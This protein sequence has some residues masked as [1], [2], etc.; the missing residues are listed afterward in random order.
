MTVIKVFDAIAQ[1]DELAGVAWD[2]YLE[3][4][5]EVN[6]LAANRHLMYRTEFDEVLADVRVPKYLTLDDG[7]VPVG[8]ATFSNRLEAFPLIAPEFYE[9]RWPQAYAAR[10]IF[11]AGFVGVVPRAQKSSAFADV[12]AEFYKVT[13]P[14]NGLVSLDVCNYNDHVRRL[15]KA[16]GLMLRRMSG[17]QSS[18]KRVDAQTFWLYDVTG[19]TLSAGAGSGLGGAL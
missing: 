5:A 15:P 18:Y 12:F 17:G 10:R 1:G 8:L 14:V 9:R 6:A 2:I 3:C 16:I 4:F 11:Y 13:E 19:K 7:G